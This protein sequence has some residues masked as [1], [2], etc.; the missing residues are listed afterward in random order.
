MSGMQII[1]MM[2]I[3]PPSLVEADKSCLHFD[4]LRKHK[5]G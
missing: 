4:Y 5:R 2:S 3:G 1:S